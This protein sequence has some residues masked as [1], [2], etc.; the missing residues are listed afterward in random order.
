MKNIK[1]I[2]G[3]SY[4]L[5]NLPKFTAGEVYEV[6]DD[7]ADKLL[8]V[9]QDQGQRYFTET[10]ADATVDYTNILHE[11]PDEVSLE[12]PESPFKIIHAEGYEPNREASIEDEFD[13]E[14]I[15]DPED[16]DTAEEATD[17]DPTAP[18]AQGRKTK[19][20]QFGKAVQV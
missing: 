16:F 18:K 6:Q 2:I 8:L 10:V 11:V 9:E 12:S 14:D 17:T 15:E 5:L 20:R 1:L 19:S 7:L 3:V 4:A 13:S